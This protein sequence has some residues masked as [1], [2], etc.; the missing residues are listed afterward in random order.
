MT[1]NK[2]QANI[3]IAVKSVLFIVLAMIFSAPASAVKSVSVYALFN[4]RAILIIDGQRRVLRAGDT[5]PEGLTLISSNTSG[6]VIDVD[7]K[8][9]QIGL[10]INPATEPMNVGN[11]SSEGFATTVTLNMG[12]DGFFHVGGEINNKSVTFL[13]DTGASSVALSESMARRLDIDFESGKKAYASTANG[14]T[15]IRFITLDKVS[16]GSI[17]IENVHAAVI[18]DPG[19]AGILLGMSF[20]SKLEMKRTGTTMELIQR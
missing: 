4:G 12:L 3:I 18:Q 10:H 7:G 1:F 19:P 20:L 17:E 15:R 13:V 14:N 6:A 16:V 2:S 8:E 5:T 11:S 9:E